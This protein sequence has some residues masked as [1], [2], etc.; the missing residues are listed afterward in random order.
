MTGFGSPLHTDSNN[1]RTAFELVSTKWKAWMRLEDGDDATMGAKADAS[2]SD[3]S[4]GSVIALLKGLQTLWR[5]KVDGYPVGYTAVVAGSGNVANAAATAT[6]A[7]VAAKTNYL[8]GFIVTGAG[9]TAASVVALTI[10]GLLGGT[11]TQNIVVP[12]G[13]TT[14]I[15][16]LTPSFVPPLPASAVNTAIVVSAAAFG[17]GN[18]N[19]AV[20]AYGFVV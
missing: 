18:T 3:A 10:T 2:V 11:R 13:V 17:A 20:M 1:V 7:A 12:A 4:T 9:A 16:P 15:I 14:S 6:L 5:S 8:S 19:A